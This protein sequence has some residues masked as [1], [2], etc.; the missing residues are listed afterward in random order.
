MRFSPG[1]VVWVLAIAIAFGL[2]VGCS[3]ARGVYPG[4]W[5]CYCYYR[6]G[7]WGT[8][9]SGPVRP[10][11]KISLPLGE[12]LLV[13]GLSVTAVRD[14][15]ADVLREYLRE[16]KVS[17]RVES[18]RTI[19]VQVLGAVRAPGIL[20]VTPDSGIID[21]ISRAGGTLEQSDLSRVT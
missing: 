8:F 12:D 6:V 11:G 7:T 21:A 2:G 19:R 10:D 14:R 15:V 17:V 9:Y 4:P 18:F 13:E 16:P 3:K 5:R 20:S 1:K